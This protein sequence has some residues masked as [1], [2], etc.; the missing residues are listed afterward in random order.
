MRFY[1]RGGWSDCREAAMA[2]SAQRL[3]HWTLVSSDIPRSQKFYAEVL[4][5]KPLRRNFPAGVE[6]G[7]TIIDFFQADAENKPS[8]GSDLQHH[9]YIVRLEDFDAW[10]E[11]LRRHGVPIRYANF[12]PVRMSILFD[13]PDGYHF[14][15]TVPMESPEAARREMEKRGIAMRVR[16]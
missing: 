4:G 1:N 3:E 7:G 2:L 10:S 15:L 11:Q 14:E 8:P 13:D 16:E 6:F 9:A 12:G 5:A